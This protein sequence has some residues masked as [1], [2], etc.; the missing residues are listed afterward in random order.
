MQMTPDPLLGSLSANLVGAL[1]LALVLVVGPLVARRKAETARLAA[2]SGVLAMAVGLAVWL[3]PR[4]AAGTFQRYAWSGPGIV[5][6]VVLYALGAGVLALQVAGPVYGFLRYG[7]VLPLGAAVAATALST[8]LFF[9]VGGE[10]GSFVLYVVLS[11]MA[12][13]AICGA[14]TFEFV[15]RRLNGSRPLSV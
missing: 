8:F 10:I 2:A 3:A 15:A 14:F 9:Q 6:G 5:L 7:F 12:V 13:G 4:V 11:P 1:G